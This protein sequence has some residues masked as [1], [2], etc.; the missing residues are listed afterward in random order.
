MIKN[1][2]R[3]TQLPGFLALHSYTTFGMVSHH[4]LDP[5]SFPGSFHDAP[6]A[7]SGRILPLQDRRGLGLCDDGIGMP[8]DELPGVVFTAV[9]VRDS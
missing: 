7:G 2:I 5:F 6:T 1:S 3:R 8:V 9:E 4:L